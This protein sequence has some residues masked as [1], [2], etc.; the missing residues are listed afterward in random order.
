MKKSQK[1]ILISMVI[2]PA[3]ILAITIPKDIS[4]KEFPLW[5]IIGIPILILLTPFSFLLGQRFAQRA[6]YDTPLQKQ[7]K[8]ILTIWGIY[9]IFI[10]IIL[11]ILYYVRYQSF[12]TTLLILLVPWF[13]MIFGNFRILFPKKK[14]STEKDHHQN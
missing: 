9:T 14:E 4:I 7:K 5:A 12:W 11:I 2:I 8:N 1:W 6:V 13:F 3:I 10:A